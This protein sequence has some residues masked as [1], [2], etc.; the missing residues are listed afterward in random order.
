MDQRR[1]QGRGGAHPRRVPTLTLPRFSPLILPSC[2]PTTLI[3][4]TLTLPSP[5]CP[6]R[7]ETA[8]VQVLRV[9]EAQ[10]ALPLPVSTASHAL[11]A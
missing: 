5:A 11:L 2:A 8:V 7:S 6:M 9:E 4:G 10:G 3:P 1:E